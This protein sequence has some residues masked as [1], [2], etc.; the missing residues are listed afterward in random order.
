VFNIKKENKSLGFGIGVIL[1]WIYI[2]FKVQKT[3]ACCFS[4]TNMKLN[5]VL[6]FLKISVIILRVLDL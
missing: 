1:M 5:S 6:F 2:K 3:K 4:Q